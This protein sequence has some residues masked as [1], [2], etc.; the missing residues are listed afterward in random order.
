MRIN[1]HN[2]SKKVISYEDV[3]IIDIMSYQDS[4]EKMFSETQVK[5][6]MTRALITVDQTTTLNQIS[7][8]MERLMTKLFVLQQMIHDIFTLQTFLTLRITIALKLLIFFKCTKTWKEKKLRLLVG[9]LQR[10]QNRL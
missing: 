6:V 2:K 10:K 5:D 9:N 8:M 4:L 7:K 1:S 3:F